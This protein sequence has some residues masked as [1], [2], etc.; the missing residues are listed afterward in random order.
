MT[1]VN[2]YV[3]LVPD[4]YHRQRQ[5]LHHLNWHNINRA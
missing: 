3:S 2:H 1:P 4:R 5:R